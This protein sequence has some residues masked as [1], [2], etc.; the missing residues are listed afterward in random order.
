MTKSMILALIVLCHPVVLSQIPYYDAMTL[1]KNTTGHVFEK[2]VGCLLAMYLAVDTSGLSNSSKD[3]QARMDAALARNPFLKSYKWDGLQTLKGDTAAQASAAGLVGQVGSL[4][5]TTLADAF[6]RFLVERTKQELDMAFFQKLKELINSDEYRDAR[7][8]FPRTFETLNA[9]GDQIY[10]YS[11]Y[12]SALREAFEADLNGLLTNL[13]KVMDLH[14]DFFGKH[15]ELNAVCHSA[16]YIGNGLLQKRHPGRIIS[17]YELKWLDDEKLVSIKGAVQTLKL[18]SESVRSVCTD[19]YWVSSDSLKMLFDDRLART[20]YLGL[21]YQQS[22]DIGFAGKDSLRALLAKLADTESSIDSVLNYVTGFVR[23]AVIVTDRIKALEGKDAAKL[24]FADYY[25]YYNA[26]LDLFEYASM[27]RTL[28]L[29][30]SLQ[31]SDGRVKSGIASLRTG[32]NIA[33][34]ITRKNFSSAI[35]NVFQLYGNV[36]QL[37]SNDP[38]VEKVKASVDPVKKFIMRYGT[39]M[40]LVAQAQNADE[41]KRAI[42]S[43]ALPAGSSR[44]KRESVLN[45][46]LNSYVGVFA[47]REIVDRADNNPPVNSFGATAVIGIA[48]SKGHSILFIPCSESFVSTS[49]FFSIIDLGAITAYRITNDSTESIP[50]VQLKDIFSPGV[51]VSFGFDRTPLSLNIGYQVGPLLRKIDSSRG[52][53]TNAYSR[54]SVSLC[55]DIPLIDFYTKIVD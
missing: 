45:I 22:G 53:F 30:G 40:A 55:V 24:T 6:A 31:C 54:W 46:S 21:V 8:L 48:I 26:A 2:R 49:L 42:E 14:N 37:E 3:F 15:P 47:G 18:F 13:P 1:E 9:I 29:L 43:V 51:F 52:S 17:E 39:L 27:I 25:G 19:H 50:S 38:D 32:G 28:P 11:A 12:M 23:Q 20:M 16:L 44:I 36:F 35:I 34:D 5:V 41:V 10:N 4:D 33:L 7:V